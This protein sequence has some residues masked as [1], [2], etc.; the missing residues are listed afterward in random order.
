M[1]GENLTATDLE[2]KSGIL[3]FSCIFQQGS[4]ISETSKI[5]SPSWN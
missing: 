3:Y 2:I 5:A 1:F 4:L